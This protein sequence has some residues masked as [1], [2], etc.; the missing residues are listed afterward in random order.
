MAKKQDGDWIKVHR[1]MLSHWV[2]SDAA[3]FYLWMNLLMRANWK[4]GKFWPGGSAKPVP[5]KRGQILTGRNSL[6]A[7]LYPE[8]DQDGNVI[9]REC[10]PPHPTTLW[11]WLKAME[12]D[13]M[14]KLDVRSKHTIITICN[15]ESYQSS[16]GDMCADGAQVVRKSCA[17]GAQVVRTIE[18]GKNNKSNTGQS[19]KWTA[20]DT[21]ATR[22]D[23]CHIASILSPE[24]DS[25]IIACFRLAK[26]IA[27]GAP[28]AWLDNALSEVKRDGVVRRYG[29]L[30]A[31]LANS[32]AA[33][34]VEDFSERFLSIYVAPEAWGELK[35]YQAK[36]EATNGAA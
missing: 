4:A 31:V 29:Y 12:S 13:G 27:D 6:H 11:R 15:Y 5:V 14:I 30:H 24:S 32:A 2:F 3:V 21:E 18:E 19:A 26:F 8:R 34:G 10:A 7:M 1:K 20:A 33:Y 28:P 35:S 25:D 22:E 23:A 9:K 36:A 17:D 16:K